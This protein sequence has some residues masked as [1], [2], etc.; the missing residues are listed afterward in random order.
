MVP[1][2]P[3]LTKTQVDAINSVAPSADDILN[4]MD[5]L[6]EEL[7]ESYGLEN[8]EVVAKKATPKAKASRKRRPSKRGNLKTSNESK[9][10]MNLDSELEALSQKIDTQNIAQAEAEATTQQAAEDNPDMKSQILDLLKRIPGAPG[11][12]QIQAWKAQHGQNG[13]HVMALG[14][15]DVYIF[16]HLQR[17]QWKKIQQIINKLQ[18]AGSNSDLEDSLKEKVIQNSIL[19]PEL[20]IE[21]FY[22]SRAGVVDS[23]YQVILLNSYF[24]SPQQAMLLTTQL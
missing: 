17:G 6:N 20:P 7:T 21:F 5:A 9:S 8:E 12:Q 16:T 1:V 19:W 2:G 10:Q 18:E 3:Q 15:E 13:V 4:N 24:L 22:G 14:E 23:L 11:A